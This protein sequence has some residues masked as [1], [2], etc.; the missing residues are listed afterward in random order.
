MKHYNYQ[1]SQIK[2]SFIS[3][4]I[5]IY[6][7]VC[8]DTSTTDQTRLLFVKI[9]SKCLALLFIKSFTILPTNKIWPNKHLL[10]DLSIGDILR[11]KIPKLVQAPKGKNPRIL[12]STFLH[13]GS[14]KSEIGTYTY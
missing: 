11:Q 8:R 7:Y 6:V 4:F 13:V 12:E 5:G 3:K 1:V 9:L 14:V 10:K 2:M